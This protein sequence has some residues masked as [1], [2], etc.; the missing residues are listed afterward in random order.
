M[1]NKKTKV[2]YLCQQC[3]YE[4]AQ[5][6]G[7]CPSCGAWNSFTEEKFS[8]PAKGQAVASRQLT[9]FSSEVVKLKDIASGDFK[10][11]ATN[12]KEF[13]NMIGGGVVPGSLILLGGAPGIG[14]S[15][16]MLHVANALSSSGTVLYIS[17]EESLAQVKAR[18]ERLNVK[19]DNIFLASETNLQ[20]I[21]DAINKIEPK[22][23]VVDSIQT[24]YHPELSS[25]PGTVGQVRETAAE[26]LRIAKSKNITVFLL[27]HVTK[28]GDLAGP[29]VLEHI[30]DTVLYFENERQHTYRILRSYKNRF[31]PTSEIG[32]FE[33]GQTGLSEV[34]NPSLIFL[35]ERASGVPGNIVTVSV[36]GTRPI[37]LEVQ[38]LSART[39]FQIP[40]RMVAGYDT[41]RITILIAVLENRLNLP[42]EM[43]DIFVNV[44]G[45]V[46][47]K[48][49][50]LDLAAAGAIVS[51]HAGFI[52]P[53][54]LVAFGE[55][56]LAGEVRSVAFCAE[57]L[58][59]AEK[60]GFKKAIVPK[61]NLKNLSYKGKIEIFGAD[62]ADA[63]IKFLRNQ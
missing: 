59:E 45:G 47:I 6:L 57:R 34:S 51:A 25:A 23:L 55:V 9:G 41:N 5:W 50:S 54:D 53:K 15:T 8:A 22:F 2:T 36:E 20:N 61:G 35:G 1:K 40:R 29:R 4:A 48:E 37:L 52:C 46:K 28:E 27:G 19:K 26:F 12:I 33:M 16:L 11:Y 7:K 13:D 18:A 44:A 49:T 30:V 62:S 32:I 14:K 3:G 17:G 39:N 31:G 60:L 58:A 42:L 24:T 56:G 38:A 21:V 63:A 10:R 43:Q